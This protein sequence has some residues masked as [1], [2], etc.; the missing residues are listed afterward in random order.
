[1]TNNFI[2]IQNSCR[3]YIKNII[4]YKT[5]L[6]NEEIISTLNNIKVK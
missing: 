2:N 4:G 6:S 5:N 3:E 1:M